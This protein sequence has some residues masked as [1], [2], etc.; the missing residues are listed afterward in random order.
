MIGDTV[1][2]PGWEITVTAVEEYGSVGDYTAQGTYTYVRLTVTN[3]SAQPATFPYDGLV[4]TDTNDQ[5]YFSDLNATRETLTF[6]LGIALDQQVAPGES[7]NTAVVF[8]IPD[9][10]T[11]LVLTTPSRVFA[12]QL[13]YPNPP[14]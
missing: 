10:V 1:G 2:L 13:I 3:T 9:S 5:S 11:G 4:I 12:V 6:D 14:K 7:T 8:D